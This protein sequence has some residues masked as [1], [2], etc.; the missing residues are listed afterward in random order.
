MSRST[1]RTSHPCRVCASVTRPARL[2]PR[3]IIL[4]GLLV[5]PAGEGLPLPEELVDRIKLH[6]RGERVDLGEH[7]PADHLVP[8]EVP[9]QVHAE[10]AL[11]LRVPDRFA[12]LHPV[13]L[14]LVVPRDDARA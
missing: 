13:L 4:C 2:P 6:T 5:R 8:P 9:L 7:P 14:H 10:R 11:H 3:A 12:D 1:L